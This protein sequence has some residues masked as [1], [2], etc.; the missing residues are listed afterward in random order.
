[1]TIMYE[2]RIASLERLQKKLIE[3]WGQNIKQ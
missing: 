2:H 3:E 1:M